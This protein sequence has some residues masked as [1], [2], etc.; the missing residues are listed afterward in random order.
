MLFALSAFSAGCGIESS[1]VGGRCRDGMELS[2]NTCIAPPSGESTQSDPPAGAAEGSTMASAPLMPTRPIGDLQDDPFATDPNASRPTVDPIAPTNV[3]L[4]H[5]VDPLFPSASN[6]ELPPTP[7]GLGCAAPL[8]ACKGECIPVASDG[9]NCGACRKLC[10][11]NICVDGECQGATPGDV[12]LIGHDFADARIGSA[13][14]RV[15][16]NAL[17]IPTTDPIRVLSYEDGASAGAISRV[18]LLAGVESGRSIEFTVAPSA[19]SLASTKLPKSY[20]IVLIHGASAGDPSTMGASWADALGAFTMKGGVV[21]ALDSGT[22]PIPELLSSSGLLA[23]GSHTMLAS[24]AHLAV[25][26]AGDVIG[27][28]VLSPYAGFGPTVSFQGIA[29]PTLDL[30]WV[31][32]VQ[33]PND[34]LADPVVVHRIVR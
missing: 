11:S 30:S 31:V 7:T 28:Q 26:S 16:L 33:G 6:Q 21:V 5:E 12:V 14:S 19:A 8:I 32:R 2:G 29:L 22:T 13:Q 3:N 34:T 17:T 9:A 24:G 25:E 20:D 18:K 4:P 23:V 27:T 15:L 1:V 10:P